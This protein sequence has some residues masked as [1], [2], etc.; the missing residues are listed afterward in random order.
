MHKLYLLVLAVLLYTN[1]NAQT[2]WL[3][4]YLKDSSTHAP[5]AGGTVTNFHTRQKVQTDHSGFF[6]LQASPN[7]VLYAF[8]KSYRFDT[9]RVSF[10]FQD[11]VTI[12]LSRT[13]HL[14]PGVT[15]TSQYNQYQV[16]SIDRRKTFELMRGNKLNTVSSTSS[17]GFGVGLSLDRLFKKKYRNQ[18]KEE[19]QFEKTE[20][21][22]YV[23][24]R[25]S[26]DIVTGYTGL[27]GEALRDFL[28]RYTPSYQWLR[29]HPLDDDIL[30]YIN[31]KLKEYR[32]IK[33]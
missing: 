22:S 13:E 25:F 9:L 2:K 17:G 8:A 10:L 32:K 4:G 7:D 19:K 26:P 31:D 21:W 23:N 28:A 6:R 11:T 18:K 27:Q 1:V 14:L 24:Y 30:Y 12:Y 5:I 3:N 20:E 29:Q 33:K 16:D 15:V